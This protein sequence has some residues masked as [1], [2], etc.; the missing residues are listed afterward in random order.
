MNCKAS[1][2]PNKYK[3]VIK[4]FETMARKQIFVSS[5]TKNNKSDSLRLI[6]WTKIWLFSSCFFHCFCYSNSN[7]ITRIEALSNGHYKTSGEREKICL[8]FHTPSL[9]LE[10]TKTH[11]DKCF[12]SWFLMSDTI[13]SGDKKM[14][15]LH[16][17]VS[18]SLFVAI[19]YFL[20]GFFC[21][22]ILSCVS[23]LCRH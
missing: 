19:L 15:S 14:L 7:W 5:K 21:V 11:R 4:Q 9:A 3:H 1:V 10:H 17:N 23:S 13:F 16:Q 22:F 6:Q 20:L 12:R 2:R 18:L 8:N